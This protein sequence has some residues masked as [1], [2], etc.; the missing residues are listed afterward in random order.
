MKKMRVWKLALGLYLTVIILMPGT[1]KGVM[2]YVGSGLIQFLW[3]LIPVFVCVGL[4][5]VWIERDKMMRMM[6]SDSGIKGMVISLLLGMVTG[7]PIYALLPVAGMLLKKGGRIS[8][9]LIFLCASV[10]IRIPLLLF[11]MSSLG[12]GFT[13]CRFVMN[14]LVV[15]VIACLV[16]KVLTE[17]EKEEIYG[18]NR[19]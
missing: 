16:E 17:E 13:L 19:E 11:E 3:N 1:S 7:I 9:V 18:M 2:G 10:S 6:G 12:V 14:L 15:F 8:N 4:M 5:D